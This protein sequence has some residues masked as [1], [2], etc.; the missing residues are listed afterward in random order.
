MTNT[1]HSCVLV[2]C[3]LT[4]QV[5]IAKLTNTGDLKHITTISVS[6]PGPTTVQERASGTC[7]LFISETIDAEHHYCAVYQI[8]KVNSR[9][10]SDQCDDIL[11][12]KLEGK[13]R[14]AGKPTYFKVINNV[15][16]CAL[17]HEGQLTSTLLSETGL[18]LDGDITDRMEDLEGCHCAEEIPDHINETSFG[19]L[20][21]CA[22]LKRNV[23][24][25]VKVTGKGRLIK[26]EEIPAAGEGP[27]HIV[28]DPVLPRAYVLNELDSHLYTYRVELSGL[29]TDVGRTD[30]GRTDVGR[31]DVGQMDREHT[32]DAKQE[33]SMERQTDAVRPLGGAI[34]LMSSI[35]TLSPEFCGT[36]W[37]A[38]LHLWS[39]TIGDTAAGSTRW[40]YTCD[41]TANEI[42]VMMAKDQG[43]PVK[44]GAFR[45]EE[46]PRGFNIIPVGN[47]R[48][49]LLVVGQKSHH[50]SV[51]EIA[52]QQPRL[53]SRQLVSPAGND[54]AGNDSA[55]EGAMWVEYFS[56]N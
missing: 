42:T 28:F 24:A 9:S 50:A 56:I 16:L 4:N 35:D 45:T 19:D 8:A 39:S 54:S 20:I 37:A 10:Q 31:T 47:D 34:S 14:M 29:H 25:I 2:S 17:Y 26:L 38:D 6:K 30:V 23:M 15:L 22:A 51:Y 33:T 32:A 12:V 27:R 11:E 18:A 55:W 21:L 46:Q 41:R 48:H 7:T 13:I 44:V 53:L 3:P 36:R 5:Q 1:A 43:L 52:S 49:Y 40:I